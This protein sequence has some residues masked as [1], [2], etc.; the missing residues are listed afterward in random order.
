MW[1]PIDVKLHWFSFLSVSD[2]ANSSA[3]CKAWVVL[4]DKTYHRE[5]AERTGTAA[6][7][8]LSRISKLLLLRRVRTPTAPTSMPFLLTMAA[9]RTDMLPYLHHLLLLRDRVRLQLGVPGGLYGPMHT[10]VW[11]DLTDDERSL[12]HYKS[13]ASYHP[14][15]GYTTPLCQAAATGNAAAVHLLLLFGDSPNART[16]AGH[17]PLAIAAEQGNVAVVEALLG[18]APLRPPAHPRH[19]ARRLGLVRAVA[20]GIGTHTAWAVGARDAEAALAARSAGA[21]AKDDDAAAA[22]A[23]VGGPAAAAVASRNPRLENIR[24]ALGDA[25]FH[26]WCDG[27]DCGT[28]WSVHDTAV[29]DAREVAAGRAAP[30]AALASARGA[31]PGRGGVG[32]NGDDEEDD[33]DE[34]EEGAGAA[35][36]RGGPA[37]EAAARAEAIAAAAAATSSAPSAEAMLDTAERTADQADNANFRSHVKD[38]RSLLVQSQ[39]PWAKSRV[40]GLAQRA[41]GEAMTRR[42]R[43]G[44]LRPGEEGAV[45]VFRAALGGLREAFHLHDAA[46]G[47]SVGDGLAR[48]RDHRVIHPR[49][50]DPADEGASAGFV[51]GR[52]IRLNAHAPPDGRTPLHLA[53]RN[54]RAEVAMLLLSHHDPSLVLSGD[55]PPLPP[56]PVQQGGAAAAD[57][58]DEDHGGADGDAHAT[59][60]APEAIHTSQDQPPRP[61]AEDVALAAAGCGGDCEAAVPQLVR[62]MVL[63]RRRRADPNMHPSGLATPLSDA[64]SRGDS[65]LVSLLVHF[66]ADLNQ[67]GFKDQ[68][69]L[70]TAALAGHDHI[71]SILLRAGLPRHRAAAVDAE[72]ARIRESYATRKQMAKGGGEA[73]AAAEAGGEAA[74]AATAG[75]GLDLVADAEAALEQ[76]TAAEVASAKRELDEILLGRRRPGAG[77]AGGAVSAA[78]KRASPRSDGAEAEACDVALAD[79]PDTLP[80]AACGPSKVRSS[81]LQDWA[82]ATQQAQELSAGLRGAAS[83]VSAVP[84]LRRVLG[85]VEAQR[86]AERASR[87]AQELPAALVVDASE[88]DT[89]ALA[90]MRA[91]WERELAAKDKPRL[92]ALGLKARRQRGAAEEPILD[93]CVD[94]RSQIVAL[95]KGVPEPWRRLKILLG[96]RLESLL[97]RSRVLCHQG[98]MLGRPTIDVNAID[99]SGY[100]ALFIVAMAGRAD[101]VSVM[102]AA[103]ADHTIATKRGKTILYGAVEKGKLAVIEA[104]LPY[105]TVY[106]LRQQT[107]FGTDV[108]HVAKKSGKREVIDL[109]DR[110]VC[111]L[112]AIEA[113]RIEEAAAL[114]RW[115]KKGLSK[116][117]RAKK[118]AAAIRRLM[119]DQHA[120]GDGA[121]G[122]DGDGGDEEDEE[123]E[124]GTAAAD[125]DNRIKQLKKMAAVAK[126]KAEAKDKE[127]RSRS[128]PR[129]RAPSVPM[130]GA[131]VVR[132]GS[133][134]E[135]AP[136]AG[137][138]AA[139]AGAAAGGWVGVGLQRLEKERAAEA[140]IEARIRNHRMRRNTGEE[141]RPLPDLAPSVLQSLGPAGSAAPGDFGGLTG[142]ITGMG[143]GAS[144][145]AGPPPGGAQR[146]PRP[147]GRT[148]M[149]LAAAAYGAPV[150]GKK[151]RKRST[152]KRRPR[153]SDQP[154]IAML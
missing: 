87:A 148:T 9:S 31:A 132:V 111:R 86:A 97:R 88:V 91:Q 71:L 54:G 83:R 137:S 133:D 115:G 135:P 64:C 60:P 105:T 118:Q 19:I 95:A 11:Q 50:P 90:N 113:R 130:R 17:R 151:A 124:E 61:T 43:K 139:A 15:W 68:T 140:R 149:K 120:D 29:D 129:A 7:A 67:A 12:F 108:L 57:G 101:A 10:D 4:V 69:P 85:M 66:G 104:L 146:Q 41:A 63:Q 18:R 126:A 45:R 3:V 8:T 107:K 99:H 1:I 46:F 147:T 82:D 47:V 131:S 142:G 30:G 27:L 78:S 53:V 153:P 152:T 84:A 39:P 77:A 44:V 20:P 128:R 72:I 79:I 93:S 144:S 123:A 81:L 92:R 14:E 103:G 59:I 96:R 125:I 98:A 109:L 16:K 119:G 62:S 141:E 26:R 23:A 2:L 106:Q 22:V 117:G 38:M 28:F 13:Q 5:F 56:P 37:N 127:R 25:R 75:A 134:G 76:G 138:P 6:P 102:L 114:R 136:K 110:H 32:A 74:A 35:S 121:G 55:A 21:A 42:W 40:P 65:R 73:A 112:D 80:S 49:L 70:I 52:R 36:G 150:V 48:R 94:V 116:K 24:L 51:I 58:D 100:T 143:I 154:G 89:E 34:E 122:E 145:A 33:D